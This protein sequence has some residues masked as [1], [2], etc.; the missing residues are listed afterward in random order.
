M[1]LNKVLNEL[2]AE[3]FNPAVGGKLDKSE[4]WINIFDKDERKT[5]QF[6][7]EL[8]PKD[9]KFKWSQESMPKIKEFAKNYPNQ[10]KEIEKAYMSKIKDN[11]EDY[12]KDDNIPD[13]DVTI[14][15][16]KVIDVKVQKDK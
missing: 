15:N 6:K 2:Q 11:F 9:N 12:R 16:G 14:K 5:T 8:D 1:K 10:W 4:R 7:A 13:V 3:Y